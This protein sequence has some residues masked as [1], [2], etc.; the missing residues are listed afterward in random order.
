MTYIIQNFKKNCMKY[1]GATAHFS[2]MHAAALHRCKGRYLFQE[3]FPNKLLNKDSSTNKFTPA[4]LIPLKS[5]VCCML[6]N[7]YPKRMKKLQEGYSK[8]GRLSANEFLFYLCGRT[9][10]LHSS[11]GNCL[12]VCSDISCGAGT[13]PHIN[14]FASQ[15]LS[16]SE[17]I[18]WMG[19]CHLQ[20]MVQVTV[21]CS[22]QKI[23]KNK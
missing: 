18:R 2:E 6:W 1:M 21:L 19:N 17:I 23:N 3:K 20:I 15:Y 13:H 16:L 22:T 11:I 7:Q 14:H 12:L 4:L 9:L 10:A 5:V 8:K